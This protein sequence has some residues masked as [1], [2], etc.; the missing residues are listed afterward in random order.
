[1]AVALLDA[2]LLQLLT[3]EVADLDIVADGLFGHVSHECL[4]DSND[5]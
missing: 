1:M 4:V 5:L 3:D 2:K